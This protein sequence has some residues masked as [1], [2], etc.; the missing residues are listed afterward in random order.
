M[1]QNERFERT[2][3]DFGFN[4]NEAEPLYVEAL[5]ILRAKLGPEHP[6][7]KKKGEANYAAFLAERDTAAP[8]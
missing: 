6:N 7:T 8:E 2:A 4:L 3:E 1:T 5:K